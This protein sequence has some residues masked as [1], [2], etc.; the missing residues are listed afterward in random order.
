V[1]LISFTKAAN[2][3]PTQAVYINPTAGG[4]IRSGIL[5]EI[6]EII[7]VHFMAINLL[8]REINQ[9]DLRYGTQVGIWQII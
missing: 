9:S 2:N 4:P 8:V 7:V 5:H 6:N 3:V 1:K